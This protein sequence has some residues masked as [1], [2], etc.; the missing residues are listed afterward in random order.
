MDCGALDRLEG[1]I[2]AARAAIIPELP[3][4]VATLTDRSR[5]AW[6]LGWFCSLPAS[7]G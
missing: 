7:R 5:A 3:A 2:D 1:T 4:A 6:V